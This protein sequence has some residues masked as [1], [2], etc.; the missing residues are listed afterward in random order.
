MILD[1]VPLLPVADAV[2]M[3]DLVD[4]FLLVVRSRQT[5]RHAIHDAVARL[6][7][8]RVIGV[9]LNDH[10]EYRGSYKG[11]AYRGYGMDAGTGYGSPPPSERPQKPSGSGGSR[12]R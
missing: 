11:Y 1:A 9:V 5:P 2:L 10:H 6:R 3:Q 8:D 4:G 12:R 7:S